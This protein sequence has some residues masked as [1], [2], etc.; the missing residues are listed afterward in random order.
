[1]KQLA[2][3]ALFTLGCC[4]AVAQEDWLSYEVDEIVVY[5]AP[6]EMAQTDKHQRRNLV[7]ASVVSR[8][9]KSGEGNESVAA[10]I[11]VTVEN[12]SARTQLVHPY[13][14]EALLH[15]GFR[16]PATGIRFINGE[17]DTDMYRMPAGETLTVQLLWSS[18]SDKPPRDVYFKD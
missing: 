4:S 7:I 3:L 18:T 15:D 16:A 9:M 5:R 6:E 8:R 13:M 14:F 11:F 12:R 1:M 17:S 10:D 2:C